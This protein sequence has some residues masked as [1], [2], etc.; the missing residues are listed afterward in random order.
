MLL[1]CKTDHPKLKYIRHAKTVLSTGKGAIESDMRTLSLY[2]SIPFDQSHLT[3]SF[4][5]TMFE[6]MDSKA[7]FSSFSLTVV[8]GD[9]FVCGLRCIGWTVRCHHRS[10]WMA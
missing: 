8:L 10:C 7:S 9:P 1:K 4:P 6:N 3:I 5:D 2:H